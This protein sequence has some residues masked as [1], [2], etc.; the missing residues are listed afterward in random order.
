MPSEFFERF[1]YSCFNRSFHA[2]HDGLDLEAL[3]ALEGDELRQAGALLLEAVETTPDSRPIIAAGLLRLGAAAPALKRRLDSHID[4]DHL[5]NRVEAALSLYQIGGDEDYAG[6]IIDVLERASPND[7]WTRSGAV[8]ALGY[9]APRPAVV[10]ALLETLEDADMFIAYGAGLA[11]KMLY[12]ADEP[13]R[14]ALEVLL[15]LNT[16]HY[17][18]VAERRAARKAALHNVR[19]L[20]EAA[21]EVNHRPSPGQ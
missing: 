3:Y 2:V 14:Q 6:I 20:I 21:L 15:A 19:D 7:Q 1:R 8:S 9:F 13:I 18:P 10:M 5:Y 17:R 16:E 11:L 12:E 4:D